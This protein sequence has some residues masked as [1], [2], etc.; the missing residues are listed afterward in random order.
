MYLR[1]NIQR[2]LFF[3]FLYTIICNLALINAGATLGYSSIVL[4]ILA[5][6][7]SSITLNAVEI[8]FF[9]STIS[10]SQIIGC[11]LCLII[12]NYGRRCNMIVC[13]VNFSLGWILIA[14]SYNV[15]QLFIG[16]MLTGIAIGMCAASVGIYLAEI[17]ITSWKTVI[18]VTPNIALTTGILIVYL[19]GFVLQNDWRLIAAFF[20][21][22]SILFVLCN[23]FFIRESPEWLLLKGRKEDARIALLCIR[24]LR[25]ETTEFQEEFTKMTNYVEKNKFEISQNCRTDFSS[26]KETGQ[27]FLTW[28]V[29]S[30]LK[31]IWRTI[32][33]PEVWKPFVIL[34]LY[35]LF[36]KLCGLYVIIFYTVDLITRLNITIDPF[37]IAVIVGVIQLVGIVITACCSKRIGRRTISIV[38]GVGISISLSILAVYLQFFEN[39]SITTIPIAC[40]LFYVGF[41]SFGFFSIPWSMIPEQYPTRYVNVLGQLTTF[42]SLVGSY[43]VIQ[44]YPVMVTHNRNATIYFYCIMSIIATI[45]LMIAL[46]ETLGKTKTQIEDAFRDYKLQIDENIEDTC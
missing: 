4:P 44:L 36:Q 32:L 37:L 9:A 46:P 10:I 33:L 6:N 24:G 16:R 31:R 7:R 14:S 19:L 25:Q 27:K 12:M 23:I 15:I 34:N 8:S 41:G 38:S 28:N 42:I 20:S 3:L 13:G 43:I 5:S 30:I 17:S 39:I 22:P 1:L 45:F 26:T 18:T 11:L 35:L 2:E 40:I 29:W 21:I